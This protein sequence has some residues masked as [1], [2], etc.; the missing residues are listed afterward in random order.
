LI[1]TIRERAVRQGGFTIVELLVAML[2]TVVVVAAILAI[3]SGFSGSFYGQMTRIQNQD[4]ARTAINQVAR[5]IR[6]ATSSA[7]HDSSLSNAIITALPQDIEFYCD[8]SGDGVPERV[9]YYLDGATLLMQTREPEKTKTGL[10]KYA[11]DY[12]TNGVVVQDAIRNG[13]APVFTYYRYAG[14]ALEGFSPN[15]DAQ[16]REIKTVAVSVEVNAKPELAKGS[17]ILATDVQIRQ[18]Y[19]GEL[20]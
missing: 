7:G 14:G 8:L 2:I 4:D 3:F 12:A 5:Y 9:R 20:K 16:R 15:S 18:R 11:E 13:A 17:V 6:M 19:E 1:Y 10:W